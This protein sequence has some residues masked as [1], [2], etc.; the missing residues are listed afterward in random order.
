MAERSASKPEIA[1]QKRVVKLAPA[2]GDW[3]NYR[4]PKVLV[5]KVKSGLYGFD[6]LSREELDRILVIHYRFIQEFLK[7]LKIDLAM[8]VEFYSCQVEQ[9]TYLNFLRTL[10]GPV[11]QGKISIPNLYESV[12][13]ICELN[14]ANSIINY[15]LGSRDIESSSR[16]LT[17]AE[18]TVLSTTIIEYLPKFTAAFENVFA[19]PGF[20]IA[21]SPD[22]TLDPSISASST[23]VAFTAE[24]SVNDNPPEKIHF[25]YPGSMLKALVKTYYEKEK[26]KP[27]NF[28]RLSAAVLGKIFIPVSA[29]LG[30]TWLSTSDLN[31][32]ETGDVVSLDLPINSAVNLALGSLLK[33]P[34]QPGI[35]N[36]KIA[37]RIAG[38]GEEE[39]Q[40]TPP[41]LETGEEE[42]K[43]VP[44]PAPE[45]LPEQEL[46]P[47]ELPAEEMIEEE[48]T[49]EEIG[50]ESFPEEEEEELEEEFPE[51]ELVEENPEE[52]QPEEKGFLDENFPEE[53]LTEEDFE[54]FPEE[55]KKE[56]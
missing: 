40:I 18:N 44:P 17:E 50:E 21:S 39:V 51:E 25:G 46:A 11:V 15:S 38:F 54:E 31:M 13:L 14:L 3:T 37:V 1:S 10:S 41:A 23:F 36:K 30:K 32:L 6:R 4:P 48:L 45:E 12:Q 49:E 42:K 56:E 9:T 22:I 16:G 26:Q 29:V 53:E 24:I 52:E 7:R 35:K 33:L 55:E 2:V 19:N 47:E 28:N 27:L 34:A 43:P 8:G 20:T 5:K